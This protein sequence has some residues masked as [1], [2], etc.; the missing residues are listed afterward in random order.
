M[1]QPLSRKYGTGG[2]PGGIAFSILPGGFAPL[3]TRESGPL[4]GY[5]AVA[6]EL[7]FFDESAV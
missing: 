3:S 1:M 4:V 7:S 6:K 5:R 2:G